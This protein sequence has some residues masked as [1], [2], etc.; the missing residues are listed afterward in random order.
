MTKPPMISIIIP[1]RNEAKALPAL[2]TELFQQE[3]DPELCEILVADGCSTD[4]T[5]QIV[6][7]CAQSSPV[8]VSL[9][10]NPAIKSSGG[11]NAGFAASNGDII[12]FLDGH[13]H[14]PSRTLL[15]DTVR[16][17]QSTGAECLCR[18]QPLIA[19][20]SSATGSAISAVRAS[21]LGHG[22]DSLIY[23]LTHSGYVDPSSSGATYTRDALLKVGPY[24]ERFDA[25][26]DVELNTRIKLAG[27]RAY[28]DPSLAVYYEPRS[29]VHGLFKQMVR[30]GRGRIRLAGKHHG[31]LSVAMLAPLFL[32]LFALA[33]A[34]SIF[35]GGPLRIVMLSLAFLYPAVV[36]AAS[37]QLGLRGIPRCYWQAPVI[38]LAI[39]FGLGCGMLLELVSL[40]WL[41]VRSPA[42][43]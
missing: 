33:A 1:V 37:I 16:I 15:A 5:Q 34:A 42:K 20:Q 21:T 18:P 6:E 3:Y 43:A 19:P 29:S 2:L 24:D 31:T 11:R 10:S 12:L 8:R 36:L 26:E 22:R 32:L 30:Y 4:G 13:C 40:R 14:V 9:L 25:C 38:Y 28:T 17:L 7:S 39:H 35:V 41:A 27:M 23:D